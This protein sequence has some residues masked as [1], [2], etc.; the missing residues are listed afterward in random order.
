MAQANPNLE[1]DLRRLRREHLI[2]E[3]GRSRDEDR[4]RKLEEARR[5]E[6][7]R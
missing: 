2:E 5:Q 6:H 1:R 7:R 4:W 3:E